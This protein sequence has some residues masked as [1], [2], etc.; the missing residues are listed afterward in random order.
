MI[1]VM[2]GKV[3]SIERNEGKK[4]QSVIDLA[5]YDATWT[6]AVYSATDNN[7]KCD[8]NVCNKI[9]LV[10]KMNFDDCNVI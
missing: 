9:G 7:V 3:I 8:L 4:L 10:C 1:S 2:S 6:I 5:K